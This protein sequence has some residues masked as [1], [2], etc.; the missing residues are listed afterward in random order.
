[1]KFIVQAQLVYVVARLARH[2]GGVSF[3]YR[4]KQKGKNI[5][6]GI[7]IKLPVMFFSY[8]CTKTFIHNKPPV[9]VKVIV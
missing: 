4:R 6:K 5:K 1:V 7:N 2:P 3:C 8:V 9:K